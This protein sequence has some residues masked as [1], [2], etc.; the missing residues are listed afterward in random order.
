MRGETIKKALQ[1]AGITDTISCNG[2]LDIAAK[3]KIKKSGTGRYR[4]EHGIMTR[5]CQPGLL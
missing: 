4:P 5:H 3:A 1:D 2:A